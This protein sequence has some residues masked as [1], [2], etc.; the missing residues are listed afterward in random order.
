[1]IGMVVLAVYLGKSQK[2]EK[3]YYVGGDIIIGL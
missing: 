1:M 2:N 3:N